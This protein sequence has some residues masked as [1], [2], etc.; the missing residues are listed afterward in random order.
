LPPAEQNFPHLANPG[1]KISFWLGLNV[2]RKDRAAEIISLENKLH[3][4]GAK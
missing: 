4:N 1:A 2:E 3:R